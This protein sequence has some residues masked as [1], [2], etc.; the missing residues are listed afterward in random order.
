MLHASQWIGVPVGVAG[1]AACVGFVGVG[2]GLG[3]AFTLRLRSALAS[4][5]GLRGP[6]G[7][8]LGAR[9]LDL[10]VDLHLRAPRGNGRACLDSLSVITHQHHSS[11]GRLSIRV[12]RAKPER[13]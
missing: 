4:A 6:R 3:L 12:S 8:V 1:K 13:A 9:M 5:S 10:F 2:R 7:L 11:S